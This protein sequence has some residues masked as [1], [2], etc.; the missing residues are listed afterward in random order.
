MFIKLMTAVLPETTRVIESMTA[1]LPETTRVIEL[2]TAVLF[3]V[4]EFPG[5]LT[6]EAV[7]FAHR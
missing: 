3:R 2:M 6:S 7:F 1:V 4:P 5:V